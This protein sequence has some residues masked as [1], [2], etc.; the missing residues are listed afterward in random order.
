MKLSSPRWRRHPLAGYGVLVIA[1]AALGFGYSV[2]APGGGRARA[3]ESQQ[4]LIAKGKKIFNASCASCHGLSGEGTKKAPSLIGVGGA[5]VHFQ[6]STGR[7]PLANPY[8]AQAAEQPQTRFTEEEIRAVAAYVDS[9][10][11]GPD[12]PSDEQVAYKDADLSLGGKLFRANCATCHN[13]AG[14][15]GALTY[16]TEAPEITD[17]SARQIYEAMLTGPGAMPVFSD[18][19]ITPEQKRAIIHYIKFTAKEP[20]LGGFG[21]GRMGPVPEGAVAWLVG[22]TLIV[23]CALWITARKHG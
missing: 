20:N 13:F 19:T 2:I 6:M 15:G 21:L 1:L 11:P 10:G 8:G 4:Q 22:L 12:I 3:A 17:A 14:E 18:Q 16:G 23:G 7:M 5:S 9:L